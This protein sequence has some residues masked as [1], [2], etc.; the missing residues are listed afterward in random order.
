MLL[1][2]AAGSFTPPDSSKC[3]CSLRSPRRR[4]RMQHEWT[5][6]A[7]H[8]CTELFPHSSLLLRNNAALAQLSGP[9]DFQT[10]DNVD[11]NHNHLLELARAGGTFHYNKWASISLRGAVRA[12]LGGCR[13]R[14]SIQ[15]ILWFSPNSEWPQPNVQEVI[16][17]P[18]T[19]VFY[20]MRIM[21]LA[22]FSHRAGTATQWDY[23]CK[24]I[25]AEVP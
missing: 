25:S 1:A 24:H 3:I 6:H 22:P 15:M 11:I 20:Q 10:I 14:L 5:P 18:W 13:A 21:K 4:T 9:P 23:E 16:I 17:P 19:F 12:A 7:P 8:N 2:Q